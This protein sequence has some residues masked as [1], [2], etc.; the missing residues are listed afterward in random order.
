MIYCYYLHYKI[1]LKIWSEASVASIGV[2][3]AS[4]T[5]EKVT[6]V[7]ILASARPL[8]IITIQ[9][10][11]TRDQAR[12]IGHCVTPDWRQLLPATV[13]QSCSLQSSLP[14]PA[15][16][17]AAPWDVNNNQVMRMWTMR[18]ET[19]LF[20]RKA[21]WLSN[22]HQHWSIQKQLSFRLDNFDYDEISL[23][24]EASSPHV[25]MALLSHTLQ[26]LTGRINF[27]HILH[28]YK[29]QPACHE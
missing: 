23:G 15:D 6:G 12:A 17:H 7:Q 8:A 24:S 16:L 3:A 21:R 26:Y 25:E 13:L 27:I 14:C 10:P 28:N 20:G 5:Q 9:W 2:Q 29:I 4:R 22:T 11:Q 18:R 1:L 19:K